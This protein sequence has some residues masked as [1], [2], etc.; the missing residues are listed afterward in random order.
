L[1]AA[2]L[3]V[4]FGEQT[5]PR[6]AHRPNLVVYGRA[7]DVDAFLADFGTIAPDIVFHRGEPS[8][9]DGQPSQSSGFLWYLTDADEES[10]KQVTNLERFMHEHYIEL[11]S[12]RGEANCDVTVFVYNRTELAYAKEIELDPSLMGMLA[13]LN[14]SLRVKIMDTSGG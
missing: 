1:A 14:F 7:F 9:A 4:A 6:E 10:Y 2:R 3:T 5:M 8:S 13:G 11:S 12:I